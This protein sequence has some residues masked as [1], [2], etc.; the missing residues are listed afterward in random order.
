[1]DIRHLCKKFATEG[2]DGGKDIRQPI[3]NKLLSPTLITSLRRLTIMAA[4]SM[5]QPEPIMMGPAIAKIVALGCTTVPG[6]I[7]MSPFNS[8]S[9]Q[10]T[11]L[12]WIVNL[13]RL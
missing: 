5:M 10:T 6:P 8:T 13:S 4:S 12:E 1:M 11:A 2:T 9:W 3:S 7:V